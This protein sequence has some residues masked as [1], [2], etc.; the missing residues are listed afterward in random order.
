MS[1]YIGNAPY[2][3]ANAAAMLLASAATSVDPATIEC[4]TAVGLGA[5]WWIEQK[6]IYFSLE[7]PDLRIGR[8]LGLLG[9]EVEQGS[10]VESSAPPFDR[11]RA[12]VAEGPVM[13]G[14]LDMGHLTYFPDCAAL[15]GA[16]HYVLLNELSADAARLHDPYG[17]P[18]VRLGLDDLGKAWEAA[19]ISYRRAPYQ[20][21]SNPVRRRE[22]S[23]NE[24][25]SGALGAFREV[26][27]AR[28]HA[29]AEAPYRAGPG[30]FEAAARHVRGG[31][32]EPLL[33]LLRVFGL[34]LGARRAHDL[35]GFLE[36]QNAALA[37]IKRD[38]ALAF[39][40][41]YGRLVDGDHGAV[42][43]AIREIG[44]LDA[45]FEEQLSAC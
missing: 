31:K 41:G 23:R 8:A 5:R 6:E 10:G 27:Q 40:D 39:I 45:A 13:L 14:P 4:L 2:C 3:Y 12:A 28:G 24:L 18:N 44:A 9:F 43:E 17:Y 38:Q 15:S 1:P 22:P 7:P 30:A 36:P 19:A 29:P 35:A 32:A 11:L 34:P 21:W 42:A 25:R 16:D 20:W 33:A 37:A 26:Y